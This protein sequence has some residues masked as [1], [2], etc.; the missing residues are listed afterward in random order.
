MTLIARAVPR[1]DRLD[2]RVD[3][4]VRTHPHAVGHADEDQPREHHA[5]QFERPDEAVVEDVARDH[6]HEGDHR[7]RREQEGDEPFLELFE[8]AHRDTHG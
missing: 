5:R 1:P 2:H 4:D 7:H 8:P 3:A 6:L